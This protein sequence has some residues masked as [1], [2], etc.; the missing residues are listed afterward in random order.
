MLSQPSNI[1]HEIGSDHI[2]SPD[3][4]LYLGRVLGW[5]GHLDYSIVYRLSGTYNMFYPVTST[6]TVD[7]SGTCLSYTTR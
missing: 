7:I 1:Q 6:S 2:I 3:E 4:N 5:T